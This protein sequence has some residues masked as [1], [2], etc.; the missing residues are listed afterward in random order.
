MLIN[1]NN[2]VKPLNENS[3][4]PKDLMEGMKKAMNAD[5]EC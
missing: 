3:I 2:N 1:N 4:R 5:I